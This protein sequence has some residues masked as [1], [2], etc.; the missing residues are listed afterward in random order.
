MTN[1]T[2]EQKQAGTVETSEPPAK[3]SLDWKELTDVIDLAA[4]AGQLLMQNGADSERVEE[5][6]HR[7]G[8][9]L[10]CEWLDVFVSAHSLGITTVS[11]DTFRTK[12]RRIGPGGVNMTIVSAINRLSRRIEEGELDRVQARSELE[13][14][15]H[16]PS[17]YPRWLVV[18]M[19]GLACAAFSRL[20]GGDWPVFGVT[21]ISASVA[22]FVRQEL[23]RRH[24]NPLLIVALVSFV[25]SLLASSATVFRLSHEPSL[26]LAATV[27]LLVPGVPLINSLD[28]LI[29]GYIMTGVARGVYGG[30][31]SLAIAL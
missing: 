17:H 31:I 29:G 8:M 30:L 5:T 14:I 13:R 20:F 21:F 23:A 27:L 12:I 16:I 4:W 3:P 26:A 22:M 1:E 2:S 18:V 28:D 9:A 24:F 7:I 25:G 10:G 19:V 6:V 11:G 15:S